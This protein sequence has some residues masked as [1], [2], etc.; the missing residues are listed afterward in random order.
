M[1]A[2]GLTFGWVATVGFFLAGVAMGWTIGAWL[3]AR[4]RKR[5]EMHRMA[6]FIH[7]L[8]NPLT[9]LRGT[10][11]L[12]LRQDLPGELQRELLEAAWDEENEL[13]RLVDELSQ[14]EPTQVVDLL[15]VARTVADRYRRRTGRP[16]VVITLGDPGTVNGRFRLLDRALSNMVAN[17]VKWGPEDHP[18]EVLVRP[19][20]VSVR[21][22]GPGIPEEDLQRIFHRSYRSPATSATPGT[23]LGLSIAAEII[24]AHGGRV[25]A[26]NLPDG[27]AEVG[28]AL[29]A[30]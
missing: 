3:V 15:E 13:E 11:E 2:D 1:P 27:G 23:G 10:L 16:I 12:V 22:H 20:E 25:F 29:P 26:R 5:S 14:E 17:A 28:F 4:R 21:D 8:R 30:G 24:R 19:G 6:D 9:G 18:I 7:E